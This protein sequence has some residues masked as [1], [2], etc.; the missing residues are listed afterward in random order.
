MGASQASALQLQSSLQI[1]E[2]LVGFDTVSSKSNLPLIEHVEAYLA[3]HAIAFTRVPDATGTRAALFATVGPREDGGVVLSGH[4]DVVPV[5]GQHWSGDPFALRRDGDRLYGRGTCDMKGFDAVAL[6]MLPELAK[7]PLR[8]PVHLLLSY[9]EEVGC[10]GSLPTIARFGADLPRP[11]LCLVGEPTEMHVV[12]A[13]KSIATYETVVR[14]RQAHSANPR[15]GGS[16]VHAAALLVAELD[17]FGETLEGDDDPTFDPPYSTVHVGVIAGG[18]A[19]NILAGECRFEWE[20]RGLPGVDQELAIRHF[21]GFVAATVLPRL[22]RHAPDATIE[23]KRDIAVPPLSAEPGSPAEVLGKR[24]ARSD[25]V[26]TASYVTEA[27]QF[28]VNGIPTI[29]C[30]PGS[31]RQAH[32][33]DEYVEVGQ[34]D[35]ALAFLRR[36]GQELCGGGTSG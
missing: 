20:F 34:L 33:P 18:S 11:A 31:I 9:D 27:G 5:A 30:G 29:V 4:S 22:R 19:R 1:L 36:L 26:A 24:L 10:L 12:N 2:A 23:T 3:S 6:A 7:L 8:K 14:G 16:A 25:A 21:D 28:Q 17:R 35:A 15:L 32:Q 13:H